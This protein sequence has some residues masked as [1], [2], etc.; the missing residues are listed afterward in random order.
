M[1]FAL[2]RRPECMHTEGWAVSV[3]RQRVYTR[4]GMEKMLNDPENIHMHS[5]ELR[6]RGQICFFMEVSCSSFC[7]VSF[8]FFFLFLDAYY[9]NACRRNQHTCMKNGRGRVVRTRIS[10]KYASA[11]LER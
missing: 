8:R 7:F 5:I 3:N 9:N 10:I 4:V 6:R 1:F 11:V 2:P